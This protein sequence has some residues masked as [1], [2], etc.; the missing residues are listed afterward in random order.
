VVRY[1]DWHIEYLHGGCSAFKGDRGAA[2]AS[3]R[4][5]RQT[6]NMFL[7]SALLSLSA[8]AAAKEMP[9]DEMKAAKLYDSGIRHMNNIALKEV[10]SRLGFR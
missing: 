4:T 1:G 7:R 2:I 9:K 5:P 3:Y 6:F 10:G 8:L